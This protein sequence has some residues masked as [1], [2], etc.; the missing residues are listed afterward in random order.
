[1]LI[2]NQVMTSK[3]E[4]MIERQV[5]ERT[6]HPKMLGEVVPTLAL[7]APRA[8]QEFS[9]YFQAQSKQLKPSKRSKINSCLFPCVR[10]ETHQCNGNGSL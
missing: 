9:K 6:Q 7:A 4:F 1:M 2:S 10:G 5:L 8:P 3:Q